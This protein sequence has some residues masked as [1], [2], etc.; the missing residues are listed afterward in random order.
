MES[1][2]TSDFPAKKHQA[3]TF[4]ASGHTVRATA[5]TL[6]VNEKT[7][8]VWK[9]DTEFIKLVESYRST[10]V[11]RALGRLAG[12]AYRAVRTLAVCLESKDGDN[13]RV[14]AATAILDQLIR[15]RDVTE[16]EARLTALEQRLGDR[17]ERPSK[18]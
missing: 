1:N 7:V 17:Y 3:A 18:N 10:M 2:E 11:D 9:Y 15:I 6:G 12:I 13:V 8:S 5:N 4:L 16:L 14:R